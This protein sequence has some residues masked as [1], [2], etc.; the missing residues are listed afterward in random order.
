MRKKSIIV[1]L[2]AVLMSL[3]AVAC[4]G[5]KY[6]FDEY[7]DFTGEDISAKLELDDDMTLDGVLD[8]EAW[9][10]VSETTK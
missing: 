9:I 8:E 5:G 10:N 6:K 1:V 2:L 3:V 7:T 4:S